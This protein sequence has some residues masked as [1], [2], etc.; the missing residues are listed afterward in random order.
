MTKIRSKYFQMLSGNNPIKVR[1]NYEE[2]T[3]KIVG[4][5]WTSAKTKGGYYFVTTEYNRYSKKTGLDRF[6]K[7]LDH[8]K[9]A[10]IT[11]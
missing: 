4:F 3:K 10:N 5:D 11:L 9:S 8:M 7:Y 1:V 2:D 6:A